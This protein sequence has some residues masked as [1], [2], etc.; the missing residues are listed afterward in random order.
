MKRKIAVLIT[1]ILVVVLASCS[2]NPGTTTMKLILSTY[3]ESTG[4]T[5]LP[6]DSSLLDVSKY[7]VSG[8]GPNGK[9]FSIDSDTN[10][11]TI[12]GLTIGEWNV[13]AKGINASGTELVTGSLSFKLTDTATPRTIVLDT[14]VGTGSFRFT[15]DWNLCSVGTPVVEAYLL[16][17]DMSGTEYK[18]EEITVDKSACTATVSESLAAGSYRLKMLL[19]DG[20]TQIA[21]L[22]EAVRISNG[23]TTEGTH[24]FHVNEYGPNTLTYIADATGTP[25]KGSLAIEGSPDSM[26]AETAYTCA[27]TFSEPSKVSTEG[28]TIEWYY[29]GNFM[30]SNELDTTGSSLTFTPRSGVHRIDAV[31]YNKKLGSTGSTNCSFTVEPN[32]Q[33]GDLSLALE[34]ATT[35][36]LLTSKTMIGALSNDKFVVVTPDENRLY[37]CSIYANSIKVEK[38]YTNNELGWL[39]D[40]EK[41]FT[42]Y[43]SDYLLFSGKFINSTESIICMYFDSGANTVAEKFRQNY[44]INNA[45]YYFSNISAAAFAGNDAI[46]IADAGSKRDCALAI[47][48]GVVTMAGGNVKKSASYYAV[49]DVDVAPNGVDLVSTC[50]SATSFV[51]DVIGSIQYPIN[52]II[53]ETNTTAGKHIRF[54]NSQLVVVANDSGFTT[55]KV[56]NNAAYT[57]YKAYSIPVVDLEADGANFFYVLD[58][59]NRIV[60]FEA[61][62]YEVA[63]HGSVELSSPVQS[64]ALTSDHF[65]VVMENLQLNV[66][67]IID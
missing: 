30:S 48:D 61:S 28:L 15:V 32:G 21:G 60:T 14:L 20:S 17:P 40:I 4:K 56:V 65:V 66:Y 59:A 38:T 22:V 58:S 43:Q 54:A 39:G 57:K 55:Y 2:E 45:A 64:F 63:Q 46:I 16:G 13:T 53:S 62:A 29:D 34:A 11:V 8:T 41:M 1:A 9:T 27:F 33:A 35:D 12:E 51:S 6:S 49:S 37:I 26:V 47:S 3:S 18:L 44:I 52:P 31:V 19:F 10:S 36:M 50:P 24:I 42:D 67:D 7:S 5:L 23:T 25:I